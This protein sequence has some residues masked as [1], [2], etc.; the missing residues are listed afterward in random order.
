MCCMWRGRLFKSRG[1]ATVNARPDLCLLCEFLE[2]CSNLDDRS[3]RQLA[4]V[5]WQSST[6]SCQ[7]RPFRTLYMI[8]VSLN[9]ICHHTGSQ[10][11]YLKMGVLL[12]AFGCCAVFAFS[13]I[14]FFGLP[15]LQ[16]WLQL[17]VHCV[18]C[19]IYHFHVMVLN[20]LHFFLIVYSILICWDW[21]QSAVR[22]STFCSPK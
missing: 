13:F 9:S 6:R 2:P 20:Q 10:Q 16:S 12:V 3:C 8:M 21:Y 18:C 22:S 7:D 19:F 14:V 4:V 15:L 17:N 1:P 11:N 5:S